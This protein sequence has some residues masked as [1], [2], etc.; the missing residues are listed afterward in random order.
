[1]IV[2]ESP[3]SQRLPLL[4][5]WAGHEE[6]LNRPNGTDDKIVGAICCG[7]GSADD[8]VVGAFKNPRL[9]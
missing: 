8:L 4:H 2:A 1:M 7:V 9:H 3:V 6:V 5:M